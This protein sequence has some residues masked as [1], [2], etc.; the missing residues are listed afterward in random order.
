MLCC[1]SKTVMPSTPRPHHTAILHCPWPN[2]HPNA[3]LIPVQ[4]YT[5]LPPDVIELRIVAVGIVVSVLAVPI[6]IPHGYHGHSTG[7]QQGSSHVAHLPLT[8]ALKDRGAIEVV[9]MNGSDGGGD[10]QV[11]GIHATRDHF[12][13]ASSA[14]LFEKGK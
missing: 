6:L 14:S 9:E 7:Q 3:L 1:V 11:R 4:P 2:P 5:S 12:L 13:I 8:E 10:R